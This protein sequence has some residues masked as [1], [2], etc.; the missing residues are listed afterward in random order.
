MGGLA[1]ESQHELLFI[2][3]GSSDRSLEVSA[4]HSKEA[5][6]GRVSLLNC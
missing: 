5:S 2:V 1:G 6:D 4:L 3:Y